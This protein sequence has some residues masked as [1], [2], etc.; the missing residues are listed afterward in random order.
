MTP[1]DQQRREQDAIAVAE[2]I[3]EA[4]LLVADRALAAMAEQPQFGMF[5]TLEAARATMGTLMR[6]V[7]ATAD[8]ADR[9]RGICEA[10]VVSLQEILTPIRRH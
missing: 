2:S 10:A 7:V 1:Q 9:A 3:K 8:D 6:H 5:A 4:M